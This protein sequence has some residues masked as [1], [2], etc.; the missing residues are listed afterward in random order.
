MFPQ[1]SQTKVNE[2]ISRTD[3]SSR[4]VSGH[5]VRRVSNRSD[6]L[7]GIGL[8]SGNLN[9]IVS[10]FLALDAC[11][12]DPDTAWHCRNCES[13]SEMWSDREIS[14]RTCFVLNSR[15]AVSLMYESGGIPRS[16]IV[17]SRRSGTS[18]L[19]LGTLSPD[20]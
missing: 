17:S 18:L 2:S 6:R 3:V 9:L 11:Q 10:N 4:T 8:V 14:I 7:D 13:K 20:H 19:C 15:V 5:V 12:T 16:P 1:S